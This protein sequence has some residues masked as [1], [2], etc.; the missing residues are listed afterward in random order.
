[1]PT[2]VYILQLLAVTSAEVWQT[3]A[4]HNYIKEDPVFKN[5]LPKLLKVVQQR[6]IKVCIYVTSWNI[7][8]KVNPKYFNWE[9]H[10]VQSIQLGGQR[11]DATMMHGALNLR[12][13]LKAILQNF[14]I[15]Q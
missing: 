15:H 10:R 12:L 3:F 11:I 5:F 6:L 1:M 7:L 8:S 14:Q 2:C 13:S 9:M 4:T